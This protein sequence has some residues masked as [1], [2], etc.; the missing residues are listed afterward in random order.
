MNTNTNIDLLTAIREL[1]MRQ[2]DVAR[3]I[4]VSDTRVS[5]WVGDKKIRPQKRMRNALR[6]IGIDVYGE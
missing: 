3:L 5:L 2:R 1:G 6:T 4:G